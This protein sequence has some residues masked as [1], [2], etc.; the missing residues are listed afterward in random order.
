MEA[1]RLIESLFLLS[2]ESLKDVQ[3]S[4]MQ[5]SDH[6]D[7]KA[8]S[9]MIEMNAAKRAYMHKRRKMNHGDYNTDRNNTEDEKENKQIGFA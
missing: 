3:T 8:F 6:K 7:S 4:A 2:S 9:E 1:S 5:S